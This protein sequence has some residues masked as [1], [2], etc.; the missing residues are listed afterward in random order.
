MDWSQYPN[1]S[2]SE[3]DCKHT[4]KNRMRPEF[5]ELLQQIRTTM[6]KPMVI[7]SGYRDPSHPVE[8][9]K[10]E[11]GE[12]SYGVAADIAGDRLFL[13]DLVIVAYGYGIRRIGINFKQGYV[14]LGIGDKDFGFPSVPWTY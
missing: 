1:F 9:A 12:H 10:A 13:L 2:K 4:G 3:F 8:A 7:T 5:M 6:G 14:H 11:A